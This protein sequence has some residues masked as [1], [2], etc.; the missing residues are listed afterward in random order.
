MCPDFRF[1]GYIYADQIIDV[2][3]YVESLDKWLI[4]RANPTGFGQGSNDIVYYDSL[5]WVGAFHPES[6]NPGTY[7]S[8]AKVYEGNVYY[9]TGP[10]V[11][12]T[13]Q[14][15]KDMATGVCTNF[16]AI[17]TRALAPFSYFPSR[18]W[19]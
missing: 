4:I 2:T 16:G 3:V 12:V 17:V 13:K 1:C 9:A 5:N 18:I 19:A 6:F 8:Y 15:F 14:S 11:N 7:A 10:A